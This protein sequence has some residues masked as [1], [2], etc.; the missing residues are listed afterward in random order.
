MV[1]A[2][3]NGARAMSASDTGIVAVVERIAG[4]IIFD[5]VIPDH[6]PRPVGERTDFHQIELRVPINFVNSGPAGGL[7]A[8]NGGNPG[9]EGREFAAQRL[10]FADIAALIGVARPYSFAGGPCL[11][12]RS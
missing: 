11:F 8:A 7:V 10:Y 5:H 12:F 9:V 2:R 6:L 3:L 4:D 1:F